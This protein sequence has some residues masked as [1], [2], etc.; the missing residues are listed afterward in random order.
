MLGLLQGRGGRWVGRQ[1]AKSCMPMST[2][3]RKRD[4]V[5]CS[6]V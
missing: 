4:G 5:D 6:W 3:M 1:V 2:V